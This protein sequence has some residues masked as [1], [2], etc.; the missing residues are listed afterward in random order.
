MSDR[1]LLEK[2]A[3]Q[4]RYHAQFMQ[5]VRDLKPSVRQAWADALYAAAGPPKGAQVVHRG[6]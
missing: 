5:A 4:R 6:S 3:R 1:E 2:A